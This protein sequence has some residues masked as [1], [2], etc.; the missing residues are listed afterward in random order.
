VIHNNLEVAKNKKFE[1]III[2]AGPAG[3]TLAMELGKKGITTAL[4]EAGDRDYS[5]NSQNFYKG[6]IE[7]DFPRDLNVAYRLQF[8]GGWTHNSNGI[9]GDGNTAYAD[10]FAATDTTAIPNRANHWSSYNRTINTNS[11]GGYTGVYDYPPN[12]R[13]FGFYSYTDSDKLIIE[14]WVNDKLYS[15]FNEYWIPVFKKWFENKVNLPIKTLY[16]QS[17]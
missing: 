15:L 16:A 11:L 8:N 6:I 7:G 14:P 12:F 13:F 2:G 17:S 10:T 4:I 1:V 3:I 5:E 9:Q